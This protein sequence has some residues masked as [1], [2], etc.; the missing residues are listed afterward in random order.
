MEFINTEPPEAEALRKEAKRIGF[1]MN[2]FPRTGALLRLLAASKPGGHFLE[3][4]TGIGMGLAWLRQGMNAHARLVTV[5]P[6]T[7]YLEIAKNAFAGDERIEFLE[8]TGEEFLEQATRRTKFDLIFADAWPGKYSHFEQ[9]LHCLAPG[10]LYV[11]DDLLPQ[12]NWP[13]G[14]QENVDQLAQRLRALPGMIRLEL[15]W[16]SGLVILAS[17]QELGPT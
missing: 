13:E 5:E 3:L 4:G 17:T 15:E 1:N 2:S 11:I 9:A 7:G 12:A 8:Q 14:H 6:E 10:G 16:C